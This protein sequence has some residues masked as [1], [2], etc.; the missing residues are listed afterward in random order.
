MKFYKYL[1]T[2]NVMLA[3]AFTTGMIAMMPTSTIDH[4]KVSVYEPQEIRQTKSELPDVFQEAIK[5][6]IDKFCLNESM[7]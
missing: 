7:D 4:S 6:L 2:P 3:I 1:K 5:K